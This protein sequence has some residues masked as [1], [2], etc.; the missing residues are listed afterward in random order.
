MYAPLIRR[1]GNP[2]GM[3]KGEAE[4]LIL[5]ELQRDC[6]QTIRTLSEKLGLRPTTLHE[7]IKA[8]ERRGFIKGYRA[9]LDDARVGA[10]YV[11]FIL[12]SGRPAFRLQ[13]EVLR[14]PHVVE[15]W[16]V[17]GEYDVLL[18]TRFRD[19]H[20][21]N[22]FLLRFREA[23][24]EQIDKTVTYVATAKMKETTE[25]PVSI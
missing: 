4:R 23:Y 21:F 16:G 12:V 11:A 25:R 2:L 13:G 15:V 22:D 24:K 20:E 18:K 5:S 7:R 9:I 17:T 8:L 3:E 1:G 19:A 6:R 14:D 10:G